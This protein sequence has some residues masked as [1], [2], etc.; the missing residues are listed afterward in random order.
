M[1]TSSTLRDV[2]LTAELIWLIAQ[3]KYLVTISNDGAICSSL[4]VVST[5][6]KSLTANLRT[7]ASQSSVNREPASKNDDKWTANVWGGKEAT[8][9]IRPSSADCLC[10]MLWWFILDS[11]SYKN[12]LCLR[13][14]LQIG[15][16]M[17][18]PLCLN[19]SW[20]VSRVRHA[21]LAGPAARSCALWNSCRSRSVLWAA[22]SGATLSAWFWT[23]PFW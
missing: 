19:F 3:A 6:D 8:K 22:A 9:S 11:N 2:S 12:F 18:V 1:R 5:D 21:P 20:T 15:G 23:S 17:H 16:W 14:C 10:H 4:T 13:G 7:S